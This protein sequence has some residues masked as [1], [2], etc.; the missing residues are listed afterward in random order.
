MNFTFNEKGNEYD[1]RWFPVVWGDEIPEQIAINPIDIEVLGEEFECHPSHIDAILHVEAGRSGFLLREIPPSR[2]KILFEGH[3]FYKLTPKPVSK[4]RPDLSYRHWTRRYYKGGS[5]E[6]T[7]LR[8]AAD[9]DM[10]NA[11]KSASWGLGQVMGANHK[12]AGCKT[13][14][15]FIVEA[16]SSERNQLRHM[17]NF[18]SNSGLLNSLRSGHWDEVAHGYNGPA[19]LKNH[20][21]SKLAHAA[22]HS[23]FA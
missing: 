21:D 8:D 22:K 11:L 12:L 4:T 19:Y 10:K 14:E 1:G 9:F 13:I 16:F 18:I 20:Y 3:Y 15:E 7:R 23:E 5:A 17:I 2:P 6:W